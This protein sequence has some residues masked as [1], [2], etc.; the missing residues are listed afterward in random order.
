MNN[1]K[2]LILHSLLLLLFIIILLVGFMFPY[3][4]G[5]EYYYQDYRVRQSLSGKLDT[6]IIG[7]SHALRS[8]KPT[9]LNEVLNV[10]SYNL[11]SPLMSMYG[12]YVLLEKEVKRNPIKTAFIE[13]S[14]N[15]LTLDRASLGFEGDLYVLG[16]LDNIS[17][18]LKFFKTAFIIDEYKKVFS[19]TIKRSKHSIERQL[20]GDKKNGFEKESDSLIAQYKT[21]GYL[22]V[23]S[24]DYSLTMEQKRQI[25]NT[26][27]LDL[28]MK[29]ENLKYFDDI[30]KLCKENDIRVVLIVTPVTEE[31]ILKYHNIDGVFS[32]YIDLAQKYNC[33]YYDFNLDKKASELYSQKTSF[34]DE[35]HM[36]NQGAEIF[37]KRLSEII[38]EVDD[39]E[40]CT[41][42]FYNSYDELKNY[43]L[44]I[45]NA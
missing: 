5:E 40:D 36:S 39:G 23:P 2:K 38:N 30:M 14:Y 4:Y 17:E 44:S 16:R 27:S 29:E 7:S 41:K 34:F 18:R 37:S 3:F 1:F 31:M 25:L 28:E 9:V 11:S 19:D 32:Q 26:K 8:V 6:L 22:E 10:N 24:N 42:E 13:L 12:R 35:T 45:S 20:I 43:I 33:E 21:F 15:A